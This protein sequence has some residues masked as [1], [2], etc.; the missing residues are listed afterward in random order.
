MEELVQVKEV[1]PWY[2][3]TLGL[4]WELLGCGETA[5]QRIK[6]EVASLYMEPVGFLKLLR[7]YYRD[8]LCCKSSENDVTLVFPGEEQTLIYTAKAL[9][10]EQLD[11]ILEKIETA[12]EH[13][14]LNMNKELIIELL[15]LAMRRE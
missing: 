15:P 5:S 2:R 1:Y 13:L 4:L 10:Y 11:V 12:E 14:W 3:R 9:S 6:A 7:P 8:V